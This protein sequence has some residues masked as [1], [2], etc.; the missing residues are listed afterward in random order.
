VTPVYKE[1]ARYGLEGKYFQWRH[2]TMDST[3]AFQAEDQAIQAGRSAVFISEI[4]AQSAWTEFLMYAN[5]V[6][7][8]EAQELVRFYDRLCGRDW[9]SESIRAAP[10]FGRVRSILLAKDF[11]A[12]P[13]SELLAA[14][15]A[16][17]PALA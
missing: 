13:G 10:E 16:P 3:Q 15:L 9:S 7:P 6:T 5:G 14:R 2:G 1:G 4:A 11:P 8:D 17:A 12:P